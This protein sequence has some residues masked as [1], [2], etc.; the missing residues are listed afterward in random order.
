MSPNRAE[1][2]DAL[3]AAIAALAADARRQLSVFLP[4]PD[5]ALWSSADLIDTLRSFVTARRQ[6]EVRL[7]LVDTGDLAR[8]HGALIALAQRLPSL[9]QLRQA[10]ADFALPAAQA[11]VVNDQAQLLLFDT[12]ERPAATF[13]D[14]SERA[15]PLAERFNDAWERARPMSELRALGI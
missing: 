10:D 7:L 13:N 1:G 9:I 6:R 5:S 3:N 12:G 15:R 14:A 11:F 8:Q 2:I 4:L